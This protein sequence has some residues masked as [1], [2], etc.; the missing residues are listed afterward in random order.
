LGGE[1]EYERHHDQL[2]LGVGYPLLTES[3]DQRRPAQS[4]RTVLLRISTKELI[5]RVLNVLPLHAVAVKRASSLLWI[6]QEAI[7]RSISSRFAAIPRRCPPAPMA[8]RVADTRRRSRPSANSC[9]EAPHS[10]WLVIS[11]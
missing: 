11:T 2:L 6:I 9:A 4:L 3:F 7:V 8:P 5:D 1:L 10:S